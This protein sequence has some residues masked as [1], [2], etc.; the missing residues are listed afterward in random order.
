MSVANT[1]EP[2]IKVIKLILFGTVPY[3]TIWEFRAAGEKKALEK[4]IEMFS[5]ADLPRARHPLDA[6]TAKLLTCRSCGEA[7]RV[8]RQAEEKFPGR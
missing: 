8:L 2:G 7:V 6:I 4:M 3:K 1:P 5:G